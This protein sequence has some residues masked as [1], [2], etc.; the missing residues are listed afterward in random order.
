MSSRAVVKRNIKNILFTV[1]CGPLLL[2]PLVLEAQNPGF[3]FDPSR[4]ANNSFPNHVG[5]GKFVRS[6]RGEFERASGR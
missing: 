5:C 2:C 3:Q 4:G 6:D 1:A